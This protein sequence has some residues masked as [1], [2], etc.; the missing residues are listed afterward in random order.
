MSPA[1][2]SITGGCQEE[3]GW[4]R[5]WLHPAWASLLSGQGDL[6]QR[7]LQAYDSV[8]PWL[9]HETLAAVT[10]SSWA[11]PWGLVPTGGRHRE[12]QAGVGHRSP[13]GLPQHHS[14]LAVDL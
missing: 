2:R 12:A 3:P 10:P 6:G 7:G 11:S 4:A 8:Q 13:I 9:S 1:R 5:H 14:T